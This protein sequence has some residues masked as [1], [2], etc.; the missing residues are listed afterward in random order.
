M[1][2]F[3]KLVALPRWVKAAGLI[4]LAVAAFL[5]WDRLDDKAAVD[6]HVAKQEAK[7][8]KARE[9]ATDQRAADAATNSQNEKDLHDAIDAA[10]KGGSV[11]PAALALNCERLRKLGRI[12]PACRRDGGDG[13]Q[14]GPQ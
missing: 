13:N 5:I 9:A 10:P 14:T 1:P 12:P 8:S 2:V 11:S 3:L 4:A 6:R 7:A